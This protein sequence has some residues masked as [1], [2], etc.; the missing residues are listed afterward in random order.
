MRRPRLVLL[1]YSEIICQAPVV[2]GRL[3]RLSCAGSSLLS[4][5]ESQ[6]KEMKAVQ[7]EKRTEILKGKPGIF[8]PTLVIP[9][10]NL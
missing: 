4:G 8:E 6:K 7:A 1:N 2:V 9:V 5:F 10:S 3:F